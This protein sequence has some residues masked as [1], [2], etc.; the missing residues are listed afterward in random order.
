MTK[1]IGQF[2]IKR[3]KVDNKTTLTFV[4]DLKKLDSLGVG[5][6][7]G[8][9]SKLLCVSKSSLYRWEKEQLIFPNR[10]KSGQ[11]KYRY[12]DIMRGFTIKYLMGELGYRKFIGVRLLLEM[13][14]QVVTSL[15]EPIGSINNYRIDRYLMKV[16]NYN[17]E[18]IALMK[19][20]NRIVNS[21]EENHDRSK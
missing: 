6:T 13:T 20:S 19:P 2:D 10:L 15:D 12:K 18:S 7:I 14:S 17:V 3:K 4:E 1:K 5:M 9:M 21:K 11:R 8:M 16:L